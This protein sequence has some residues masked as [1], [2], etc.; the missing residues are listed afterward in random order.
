MLKRLV[1]MV[2]IL[3]I[4]LPSLLLA[5]TIIYENT[6]IIGKHHKIVSATKFHT[7]NPG[8]GIITITKNQSSGAIKNGYICLNGK[9]IR[10]HRFLKTDEMVLE[11]EVTVKAVNHLIVMLTGHTNASLQITIKRKETPQLPAVTIST[12]PSSINAGGSS[13][14]TWSSTNA[15]S[16]FIDEGIGTVAVNGTQTVS[17]VKTTTYNITATGPGG[18]ATASVTV[19]VTSHIN[20]TITSPAHG[21][22]LSGSS[23]LVK[24]TVVNSMNKET[25]VKVNGIIATLFNNEFVVNKVPLTQGANTINVIASDTTG[26]TATKSI[27]VNATTAVNYIRVSANPEAGM[28]PMKFTLRINGS[29]NINNPTFSYI[30]P[31]NLEQIASTDPAEYKY[32][33]TTEGVY[34]ITAQITGPDNNVCQ[35]TVSVTVLPIAQIDT[36]LRDKWTSMTNALQDGNASAALNLIHSSKRAHYQ[37]MFNALGSQLPSITAN[38]TGLN[39]VSISG[40]KAWYDLETS[41]SGG[42]FVYRVVFVKDE[43]GLW[44]IREF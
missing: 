5:S 28:L 38:Y 35:D 39:M 1:Y 7:D 22:S 42:Q 44:C 40:N 26:D 20:I 33:A 36:L 24:G 8:A 10:L 14:L 43:N 4:S 2:V 29:F 18:T 11:K 13:T 12:N 16:C 17:P 9:Y 31:G 6:Y 23:V 25:G 32:K 27:A 21:A 34:Y 30:G 15:V 41:E 37:T 3:F 19:M